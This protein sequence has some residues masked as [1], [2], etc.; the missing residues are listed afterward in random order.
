MEGGKN[1]K[2]IKKAVMELEKAIDDHTEYDSIIKL[3]ENL[4]DLV[5]QSLEKSL[6]NEE[7]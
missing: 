5:K 4:D 7:N 3:S 6:R 1:E 2:K